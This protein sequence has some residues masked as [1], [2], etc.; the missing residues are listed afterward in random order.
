MVNYKSRNMD[1]DESGASLIGGALN[2]LSQYEANTEGDEYS[3]QNPSEQYKSELELS[4]ADNKSLD[5]L[6][7]SIKGGLLPMAAGAV[8][9]L[10][11]SH[12][13]RKAALHL[14]P[15]AFD[16]LISGAKYI[17]KKMKGGSLV[18]GSPIGGS[19]VGG[20]HIGGSM[21]GGSHIGGSIIGGS[22]HKGSM[23]KTHKGDMDFTTKKGD[24]DYHE[25]G[26][27]VV[28]K[29]SPYHEGA[30]M[31]IANA[32][33]PHHLSSMLA[34]DHEMTGTTGGNFWD[35]LGNVASVAGKVAPL[36]MSF[37]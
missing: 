29:H 3:A 16:A 25:K 18:G 1:E 6:Q 21:V 17:H 12:A 34:K 35:T 20:S 22:F 23:S 14:T 13:A 5:N 11:A 8:G 26:H 32:K 27:D 36:A 19:L 24:K 33:S 4:D 15:L 31:D 7:K 2:L 37:L 28:M 30:L 10:L 9:S